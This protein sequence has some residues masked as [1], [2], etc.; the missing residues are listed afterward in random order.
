MRTP[1]HL[2]LIS[3][4]IV[5]FLLH[6]APFAPV[7]HYRYKLQVGI[8]IE[9]KPARNPTNSPSRFLSFLSIFGHQDPQESSKK[10]ATQQKSSMYESMMSNQLRAI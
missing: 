8:L 9:T 4:N 2:Y 6:F 7:W 3:F 1:K 5:L 10:R